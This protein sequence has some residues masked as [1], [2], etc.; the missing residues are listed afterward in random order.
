MDGDVQR[1]DGLGFV[2][3]GQGD[4]I[5]GGSF[6]PKEYPIYKQL[7]THLSTSYSFPGHPSS[8]LQYWGYNISGQ[9]IIDP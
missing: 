8:W 1:K 4:G 9:F 2:R 6:H 3:M 7:I 5:S